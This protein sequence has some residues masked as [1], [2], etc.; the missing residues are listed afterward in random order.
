M[1]IVLQF[2]GWVYINYVIYLIHFIYSLQHS[3]KEIKIQK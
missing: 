3:N 2:P 1:D